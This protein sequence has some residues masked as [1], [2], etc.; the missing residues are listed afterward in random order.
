M[1]LKIVDFKAATRNDYLYQEDTFISDLNWK[2]LEELFNRNISVCPTKEGRIPKIIHQIWLGSE[3][4]K[5]YVRWQK[6]WTKFNSDWE[7]KLWRDEEASKFDFAGKELFEKTSNPG[8]K[9]DILRYFILKT[10]G[11][12]YV[13]TDFECLRSFNDLNERFD[14]Y[15]G[16]IYSEKPYLA[17]GL[18]GCIPNHPIINLICESISEPY[19]EQTTSILDFS[20]PGKFTNCVFESIFVDNLVNIVFPVTYFYPFPN[21]KLH[22][23]NPKIKRKFF[24]QESIAVHHWE[25]S[26][27]RTTWI[28]KQLFRILKYIPPGFKTKMKDILKIGKKF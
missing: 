10:F 18:I 6:S 4:P 25:V 28:K 7:Y 5:S 13:D 19:N 8:A 21:N 9:S 3:F 1:S 11:G 12:V 14:F 20:G 23:H 24:K 26:W 22:I 15:T 17:N 2:K 16:L 27:T